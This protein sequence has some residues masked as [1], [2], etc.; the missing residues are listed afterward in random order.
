MGKA[1]Q[2]VFL[3]I[4]LFYI[5]ACKNESI[6][7]KLNVTSFNTTSGKDSI[8][9]INTPA[10]LWEE[11]KLI[12]V[13]G[14][15]IEPFLVNDSGIHVSVLQSEN[16]SN[17]RPRYVNSDGIVKYGT[18]MDFSDFR[19][20][21]ELIDPFTVENPE[22]KKVIIYDLPVLIINTPDLQPILSKEERVINCNVSIVT[23]EK[24]ETLVKADIKGR[25][26]STW[27][28][29]KK[30]YNIKFQEKQSILGMKSSK[31]WIL[32]ANAFYDRTQL[33]NATAFELAR[34][35]NYEWVQN[36]KFVELILNG[37]HK[38]L[39]YLC[40]KIEVEK[41]KI[42]IDKLK[43]SDISGNKIT[44][45]YLL[46]IDNTS[47]NGTPKEQYSFVSD[48]FIYTGTSPWFPNPDKIFWFLKEPDENVPEEQFSYIKTFISDFENLIADD[49]K[50]LTRE[51]VDFLDLESVINWWL[52]E[53]LALNE[54]ASHTKNLY[55]YKKRNNS[56]LFF[57]PPWDL[58]AWTFGL[59]GT[60]YYFAKN[61]F[62]FR[63]L[64]KD[65]E[66][67]NKVKSKWAEYKPIWEEKIPLFIDE[68]YT[69]IRRAAERN[70]KMWTDWSPVCNYGTKTYEQLIIDMKN[71]F[72]IQMEWMDNEINNM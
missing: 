38:G 69:I 6:E 66:F 46:E 15:E 45:G 41:S 57:G 42:N 13:D 60:K 61:T 34:L 55:V 1:N 68:Q 20:E 10:N 17:L 59:R 50:L 67:V 30:P 35:T 12:S 39:Y 9:D 36:G 44:G 37:E 65:P 23:P 27:E 5:I 51:Y 62:W 22:T 28:Q 24:N 16:L 63:Q 49:D 25:G 2:I 32:L 26:N 70:E 31:N 56:K 14:K 47:I 21:I 11:L 7:I 72:F 58:D 33:H 48:Y 52:I 54:E 43:E 19:E 4:A 64:F 18:E 3:T 71:S 29:P 40:E 8:P 53:E